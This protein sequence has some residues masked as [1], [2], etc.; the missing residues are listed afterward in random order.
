MIY[1]VCIACRI[2]QCEMC[3]GPEC[4]CECQDA[5]NEREFTEQQKAIIEALELEVANG[6]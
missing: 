4:N 2:G 5:T 1:M 6:E 3:R